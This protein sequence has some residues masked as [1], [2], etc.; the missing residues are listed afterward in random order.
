MIRQE[1]IKKL[2]TKYQ[3]SPLAIAREYC[4]HNILAG[5]YSNELSRKLLFKGGTA[6]RIVYQ[7]PRFSE[8]LDFTGVQNITYYEIE[9]LLTETLVN[10][11]AWGLNLD[12]NEAKKTTGGYLGKI[13]F[14]LYSYKFLIH[15][16]ISFRQSHKKT[17]RKISSIKND[18]IHTYSIIHLPLIE[19][20]NG[21][22][23]ALMSR[24]KP[25][26]WYDLYFFLHSQ[27][28]NNKQKHQLPK[29]LQK[30]KRTEINFKKEL[31]EFLP[32]S[33][34]LILKDFKSILIREID[35]NI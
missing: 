28:L 2:S 12:I 1:D 11:D 8:D 7:S 10:L 25:R 15:L 21:K 14:R 13:N 31:K 19:I 6:L 27:M 35:K 33:H 4:Q 24:S 34:H 32:R 16:E 26:D 18:Y 5:I 22:I 17:E 30:L 23:A 9:K 3:I 29:I 20:I